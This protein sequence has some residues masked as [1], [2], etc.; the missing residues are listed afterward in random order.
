MEFS[1]KFYLKQGYICYYEDYEKL[2]ANLDQFFLSF[3]DGIHH[4]KYNIPTIIDGEVLEKCGYFES[5][6][7]QLSPVTAIADNKVVDIMNGEKVDISCLQTYDKYLTPSACLHIYPMFEGKKMKEN[8]VITTKA[9]VYRCEKDGFEEMTR[10]WDFSVREFVF[11]GSEDFVRQHLED[12]KEKAL[13][14]AQKITKASQIVVAHDHFY[15][16]KRNDIKAKIQ[17]KNEQKF[18]LKI[19]IAN[20]EV[21]VASF[22]FHGDHFSTPFKFDNQREFVSGCVG[23]GLDRW[24]AVCDEYQITD[25][26]EV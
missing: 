2:Y 23:F 5:F 10:L 18:E 24:M 13:N 17:M 20:K 25:I 7:D 1:D 26:S 12:M 15:K 14:F 21:S 22:N 16:G 9:R 8:E 4:K 19:P 6:P 11:I 3:L